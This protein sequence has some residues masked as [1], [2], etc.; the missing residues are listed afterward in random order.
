[1]FHFHIYFSNPE[2]FVLMNDTEEKM[3]LFSPHPYSERK[4]VIGR[5]VSGDTE[6]S[7]CFLSFQ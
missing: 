3:A 4:D 7:Y 1:M 6:M 2:N 5:L